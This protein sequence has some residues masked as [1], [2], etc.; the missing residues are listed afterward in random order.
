MIAPCDLDFGMHAMLARFTG[1]LPQ[2]SSSATVAIHCT[3]DPKGDDL[4]VLA[5]QFSSD[6]LI[7]APKATLVSINGFVR[8]LAC[9]ETKA[10]TVVYLRSG[11]ATAMSRSRKQDFAKVYVRRSDNEI[12]Q[13]DGAGV[14]RQLGC[15]ARGSCDLGTFRG[16]SARQKKKKQLQIAS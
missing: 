10:I 4:S 7:G 11:G 1:I 8:H 5:I 14:L 9:C 6:K 3:R 15:F 13:Y 12:V 16:D 2:T